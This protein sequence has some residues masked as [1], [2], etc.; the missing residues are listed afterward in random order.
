MR[1]LLA[2]VIAAAA[3]IVPSYATVPRPFNPGFDRERSGSVERGL[4]LLDAAHRLCVAFPAEQKA[5]MIFDAAN[6]AAPIDPTRGN[7]W[8][9]EVWTLS[10][11]LQPG[12]NR[13]ALQ[14]NA[15]RDLAINNPQLALRLFKQQDLPSSWDAIHEV[16]EDSRSLGYANTLFKPVWEKGGPHYLAKLERLARFL[17]S[18]GQYPYAAMSRIAQ[19]VAKTDQRSAT[20]IL[21]DATQYFRR[22]PGFVTT[23]SEFVKFILAT[24][25]IAA[26]QAFHAELIAVTAALQQPPTS[27]K[28]RTYRIVATTPMGNATFNSQNEAL[29][30]QLLPFIKDELPK[31]ADELLHRYT[32]LRTAPAITA[33]TPV[34]VS[35]SVSFTGTADPAR[36]QAALAESRIYQVQA[37]ASTDP[38]SALSIANQIADPYLRA[39]AL[40]SLAPAYSKIDAKQA[41]SWLSNAQSRLTSLSDAQSRLR[42]MSTVARAQAALGRDSAASVLVQQVF[43]LAEQLFTEDQR[44]KPSEPAYSLAGYEELTDLTTNVIK[45]QSTQL[46]VINRIRKVNSDVLRAALLISSAKGILEN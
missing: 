7:Q 33:A 34:R 31:T 36:M 23:N 13:V 16:T 37:S 4:E 21:R 1:L 27:F 43:D 30:F 17:G 44:R 39:V 29:L 8:A 10:R 26:V 46:P 3:I 19:D 9:L 42:L 12:Q 20:K 22:D 5:L 25:Q 32:S 38:E 35:S 24:R 15:L 28:N 14:K 6:V 40:A 11:L 18:T 45:I 41:D 2:A